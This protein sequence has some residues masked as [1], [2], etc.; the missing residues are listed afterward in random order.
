MSK[1]C[2][3]LMDVFILGVLLLFS[4]CGGAAVGSSCLLRSTAHLLPCPGGRSPSSS[5]TPVSSLHNN[6]ALLNRPVG[7]HLHLFDLKKILNSSHN[8]NQN[9]QGKMKRNQCAY[10]LTN[11][12]F[13]MYLGSSELTPRKPPQTDHIKRLNKGR[14]A[15]KPQPTSAVWRSPAQMQS[16]DYST[17]HYTLKSATKK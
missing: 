15:P 12:P 1:R 3:P 13:L 6:T 7:G 14:D 9:H 5:A 4:L 11:P 8:T 10:N 17:Y 2:Q 16:S